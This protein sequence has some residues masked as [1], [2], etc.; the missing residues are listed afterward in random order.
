L[1][2]RAAA[3]P[4]AC[5]LAC[6]W[7]GAAEGSARDEEATRLLTIRDPRISESS[8]LAASRRHPG[9]LYTH[10]D[11]GGAPQ[12]FAIGPDGRTLATL[13]LAGAGARDWEGMAI[14]E[15]EQG[16]PALFVADI[17]DN[18]G[19][20]WPHVTVYRI[21]EPSELRSQTLRATAFRFRYADGPR[22]AETFMINPRTNRIYIA[23][24]Q[25][26]GGLYE[27]PARLRTD[28]YN[29][30]RKVGRAPLLAT[31]GA[32]A[33]DGRSLVIRTYSS[34]RIYSF[35]ENAEE[36]IKP[37]RSIRLPRQEQGESITYTPDGRA[38]LAGSEGVA[39]PIWRVP[40]PERV[41]PD[42]TPAPT[43]SG[44]R[45]SQ[46]REPDDRNVGVVLAVGI[47]LAVGYG[48][49]RRRS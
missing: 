29:I 36:K 28:G 40:L 49:L 17:G 43:E 6:A 22:N 11:S 18:H 9:V 4:L 14:G 41:R 12:I 2:I 39:Q 25:L 30:L 1:R 46:R 44:R 20:I 37:L 5:L 13:T 33:P 19:G 7:A 27:A 32:F 15:D 42:P 26:S 10:N 16:R 45:E 31:D 34:A 48:I 24:K 23:S 47:A 35:D 3:I 38:L 21:P 8:G